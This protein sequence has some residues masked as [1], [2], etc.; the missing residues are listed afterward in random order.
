MAHKSFCSSLIAFSFAL[1]TL[2]AWRALA[3]RR[4]EPLFRTCFSRRLALSSAASAFEVSVV[5]VRHCD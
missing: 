2:T 1:A 5:A 3:L 4:D